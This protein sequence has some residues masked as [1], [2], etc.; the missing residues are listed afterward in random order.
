VQ[1]L[2]GLAG[3]ALI[4]TKR[5]KSITFSCL[6][7]L[8]LSCNA[9][10]QISNEKIV[11][12]TACSTILFSEKMAL[13][14]IEV[15]SKST[16]F[17]FDT[18]STLSCLTDPKVID[19]FE[20]KKFGSL[21]SVKGADAKKASRKLLPVR[22]YSDLFDS[23]NKVLSYIKMPSGKCS[24]A[25]TNYSGILGMD[26][27]FDQNLSM[28]MDFTNNKICNISSGQI[29]SL[30]Q[31]GE[32]FLV[33]SSC[34]SHQITIYLTVEEKEYPFKLDTGFSGSILIP[35][36]ESLQFHNENKIELEGSLF[37]TAAS[38][39][40]GKETFYEKMPVTFGSIDLKAKVSVSNSIK[41]QNVGI[42]FIKCFDWIID[43]NHNRVYIKRNPNKIE[44]AFSRK[45]MYYAK[46]E[47]EELKVIIK[48]KSQTKYQLGDQ[49]LSVNGKKVTPEN[50]CE[51]QDLLNKTE[52]WN[53]LDLEVIPQSK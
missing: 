43:Y 19:A 20:K 3:P 16:N 51:M 7:L 36:N 32:Y 14:P 28:Q 17:L 24:K 48:E 2:V 38:F 25:E 49:I 5:M 22:A 1:G 8:L 41:A 6:G 12:K 15:D 37:M 34:K 53:T 23:E 30:I 52:D 42:E 21:T 10:R 40:Q 50:N 44:S 26:V 11:L 46:T 47:N 4:K 35:N 45:V 9:V 18:G 33:K 13:L 39:T 27:F 31:N 29:Q